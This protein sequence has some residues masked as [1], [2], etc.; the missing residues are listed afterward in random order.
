MTDRADRF[1]AKSKEWAPGLII[2]GFVILI[3]LCIVSLLALGMV[4]ATYDS[5]VFA[6][7]NIGVSLLGVFVCTAL[8]YGCMRDERMDSKFSSRPF[9]LMVFIVAV[10]FTVDQL[11]WC[12]EGYEEIM[13]LLV[14]SGTIKNILELVLAYCFWR[15]SKSILSVDGKVIK[16]FDYIAK[17]AIIPAAIYVLLNIV[18]PTVFSIDADGVYYRLGHFDYSDI[19]VFIIFAFI[20]A[21]LIMSK[22][23]KKVKG[24]IIAFIVF[25]VI[26]FALVLGFSIFSTQDAAVL[27]GIVIMYTFLFSEQGNKLVL[28]ETELDLANDIQG[29]M[30]PNNFAYYEKRKE[31]D[32]FASMNPAREVGGDY[33]DFYMLDDD[34]LCI[35]IGD[36][37]GKG[38]PAALFMVSSKN[39]IARFAKSSMSPARILEEAN[40]EICNNNEHSFFVTEWLGILELSTGRL[41]CANAGHEYPAISQGKKPF[42]LYKDPHGIFLGVFE[43]ATYEDY[44]VELE[45]DS[46]VFVYTDGVTEAVN[47]KMELFGKEHLIES[48]NK[49]QD[50]APKGIIENVKSDIDEYAK[51]KEQ[52]DDITMLCIAYYGASKKASDSGI[53]ETTIEADVNMLHDVQTSIRRMAESVEYDKS[54]LMQLDLVVEEIFVNIAS[55]AYT[56]YKGNVTVRAELVNDDTTMKVTFIDKGREYN[57]LAKEDPDVT[58][59]AK[60]RTIGGLGIYLTKQ[61]TEDQEY[62]FVDMK[63]VFTFYKNII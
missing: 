11:F 54:K 13:G 17:L 24:A 20:I 34:H 43:E 22:E 44:V 32:I 30:L 3:C 51:N 58:A 41:V 42:E 40:K 50:E 1:K 39:N 27:I 49:Y 19:Y 53:Y 33:Y 31:I 29:A 8:Y 52:F 56:P 25:P 10:C 12:A 18:N 23:P 62:E 7:L 59:A 15:Y 37:S 63:N 38:V 21:V 9:I 60:D 28:K 55:Y 46:K 16:V 47:N 6:A 4:L 36:V 61:F 45:P 5:D 35:S 48:L 14:V 2:G 26:H 57:P